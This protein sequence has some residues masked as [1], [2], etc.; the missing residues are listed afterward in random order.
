[1]SS[2]HLRRRFQRGITLVEILVTV[3]IISV[4]LLGVAALH[5]RSLQNGQDAHIRSQATAFASDIIDRMRANPT[6]AKSG[7]YNIAM[8]AAIPTSITGLARTDLTTWRAELA[9]AMPNGTASISSAPVAGQQVFTVVIQWG[10]RDTDSDGDNTF[11][12]TTRAEL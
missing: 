1:M 9:A 5:V 6:V 3:V 8:G 2:A 11:S 10:Q 7:G 4:G 12:F